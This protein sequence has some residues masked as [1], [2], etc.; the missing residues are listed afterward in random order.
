MIRRIGTDAVA[1]LGRLV[2]QKKPVATPAALAAAA[3]GLYGTRNVW[4]GALV[5]LPL[6]K[7]RSREVRLGAI[8][9]LSAMPYPA[10]FKALLTL[11]EGDPLAARAGRDPSP[12]VRAAARAALDMLD[13][14]NVPCIWCGTDG[15]KLAPEPT[16]DP[17][18]DPFPKPMFCDEACAAKWA[19]DRARED[20]HLCVSEGAWELGSEEECDTCATAAL[21]GH[22][23]QIREAGSGVGIA[24]AE[25]AAGLVPTGDSLDQDRS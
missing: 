24:S 6:L 20:Y 11:A 19:L 5:L 2:L 25:T 22:E 14:T 18:K 16:S 4:Q 15:A 12:E 3:A 9:G 8:K 21:V 1:V 23:E 10:V 7:H 17:N 13:V